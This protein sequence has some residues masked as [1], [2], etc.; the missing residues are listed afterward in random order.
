MSNNE[1]SPR[2][3]SPSKR[4]FTPE[5]RNSGSPGFKRK[6]S[7]SPKERSPRKYSRSP[8]PRR[9]RSPFQYRKKFQ[10]NSSPEPSKGKKNQKK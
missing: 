8:P 3:Q 1:E 6:R 9:R 4:S 5:R 7:Y 10:R 2:R